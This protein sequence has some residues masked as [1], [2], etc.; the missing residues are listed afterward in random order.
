MTQPSMTRSLARRLAPL[1]LCAPWVACSDGLPPRPGVA[2]RHALL[3]T[4]AG[5]RADHC[6][7]YLYRRPAT[8]YPIDGGMHAAGRAL[9][10]DELAAAGVLFSQAFAPSDLRAG[11]LAALHTGRSLLETGVLSATDALGAG[12]TTLAEAFGAA[13]FETAAFLGTAGDPPVG[14]EQGFA[15]FKHPGDDVQAVVRAME[16]VGGRDFGD[17]PGLF[18]WLHLAGPE[19]PWEPGPMRGLDGLPL[20]L[21]RRFADPA[22]RGSVDGSQAFRELVRSGGHGELSEADRAH[23]VALYDGELMG[24]DLLLFRFLDAYRE[25]GAPHGAWEATALALCGT[26]GVEL[27]EEGDWGSPQGLRD[28]QLRVPLLLR[29]PAS[30]TGRRV[31]SEV[32][33]IGDLAATLLDWFRVPAPAAR[34]RSLLALTDSYVERPFERRPAL[35]HSPTLGLWTA[36]DDRNRVIVDEVALRGGAGHREQHA[37]HPTVYPTGESG[38]PGAAPGGVETLVDAIRRWRNPP[39]GGP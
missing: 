10:L 7:A 21:A 4:V 9:T 29:H 22:Y 14:I 3:I 26:G 13:G 18:L 8:T 31:L 17:G 33:E 39:G 20:H 16:Y 2:P 11:S 37:V 27:F 34:S 12:E 15:V 6:S 1:A 5:M 35:A 19:F 25:H 28:G 30:L 32:V 23:L 38:D 36:R 24:T